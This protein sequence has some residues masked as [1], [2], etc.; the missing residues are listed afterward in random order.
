MINRPLCAAVEQSASGHILLQ[1]DVCS[2]LCYVTVC[3]ELM[4]CGA[5]PSLNLASSSQSLKADLKKDSGLFKKSSVL[6][7]CMHLKFNLDLS[8]YADYFSFI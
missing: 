6:Q 3:S 2:Y 1:S 8:L 4:C 7:W 5:N